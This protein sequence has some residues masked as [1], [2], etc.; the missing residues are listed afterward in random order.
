[1]NVKLFLI[2]LGL[3]SL[4]YCTSSDDNNDLIIYDQSNITIEL[5]GLEDS[6]CPSDVT[7]VWA[8]DADVQFK[9]NN[10][11]VEEIFNLHTNPNM[12]HH[13]SMIDILGHRIN[14]DFVNPY[15]TST[16]N[17]LPLEDYE[18]GLSVKPL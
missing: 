5:I 4:T 10:A 13:V 3:L 16:S 18:I 1:M 7:C 2:I 6:R 15:P 8:G 17:N 9:I 11:D 14:L 12:D